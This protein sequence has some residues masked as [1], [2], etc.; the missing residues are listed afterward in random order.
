MVFF[1]DVSTNLWMKTCLSPERFLYTCFP[2]FNNKQSRLWPGGQ[3]VLYLPCVSLR[4]G[5]AAQMPYLV[6][7]FWACL[8]PGR[9]SFLKE[10]CLN[11]P[12]M[13]AFAIHLPRNLSNTLHF[14][15][16]HLCPCL[17]S[18][19]LLPDILS[20]LP[21]CPLNNV[22][23]STLIF[24][25]F[26]AGYALL[27]ALP[28]CW[29]DGQQ[30]GSAVAWFTHAVMDEHHRV[31]FPHTVFGRE[32]TMRTRSKAHH[33]AFV[34]DICDLAKTYICSLDSEEKSSNSLLVCLF[35]YHSIHIT[36][37][38]L[39]K[40]IRMRKDSYRQYTV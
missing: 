38:I 29:D 18:Q 39:E 37:M 22:L 20:L 23:Q 34:E 27:L 11:S 35:F 24:L 32:V 26:P 15:G 13:S 19:V 2:N 14:F 31:Y 5:C 3:V 6:Y 30:H 4:H 28:I 25:S 16:M 8:V 9:E 1:T 21:L 40:D 10:V 7:S 36:T 33:S 12:P 17:F